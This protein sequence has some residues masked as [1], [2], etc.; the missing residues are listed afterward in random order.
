M[1]ATPVVVIPKQFNGQTLATLA[2]EVTKHARGGWPPELIFDFADLSFIRPAGVVF[3]SNLVYWLDEK[4]TR[5]RFRNHKK[6][7]SPAILF[8]RLS[9]LSAASWFKSA[10]HSLSKSYYAPTATNSTKR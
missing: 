9:F 10:R 5:V 2:A 4:K 6:T 7:N 3:L 1:A 8:R